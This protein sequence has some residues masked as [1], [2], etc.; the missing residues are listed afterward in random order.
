M[1]VVGGMR[2]VTDDAVDLE[3]AGVLE[4][5]LT[6][7]SNPASAEMAVQVAVAYSG[8]TGFAASLVLSMARLRCCQRGH[9]AWC[10]VLLAAHHLE[11]IRGMQRPPER[12][13]ACVL[14]E[15]QQSQLT[16]YHAAS[17]AL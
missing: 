13:V 7:V 14:A 12:F 1:A 6:M 5:T 9:P 10:A 4:E 11:W 17:P 2:L 15:W 16:G 3:G 8:R